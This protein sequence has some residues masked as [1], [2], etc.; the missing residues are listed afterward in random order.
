[1]NYL[2]FSCGWYAM[3]TGVGI[4]LNEEHTMM[5]TSYRIRIA[6]AVLCVMVAAGMP[7]MAETT[8]SGSV[9]L[10]VSTIMDLKV[11]TDYALKVPFLAGEGPL[12]S[13]NN[14]KV[15]ALAGLSP[16]AVTGAVD[17]V[18]TPVAVAELSLGGSLGTG[19]DLTDSLKG[20]RFIE[21]G[22]GPIT[23]ASFGGAY[24]MGRTGAALQFD[25]GAIF[26]GPWSSVLMRTYHELNMQGF[27][28]ADA[29]DLWEYELAG[30]KRNGTF[31]RAEYVVGYRMPII[32][33]LVAVM[34][35]TSKQ[36]VFTDQATDLLFDVSFVGNLAFMENLNLT[37][38]GQFTTKQTDGTTYAVSRGPWRF[39]RVVGMLKYSF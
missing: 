33:N 11:E 16:I 3:L 1:M 2:Y 20:L 32:L 18:L 28:A 13:G 24:Y 19:W 8:S 30:F 7:V 22:S 26:S 12:T 23:T 9:E 38:V 15:Q 37:V 39:T 5:T 27:S 35:E 36:Y 34:F 17:V 4:R 25:T 14:I 31:Y 6:L 29:D 21:D 10:I